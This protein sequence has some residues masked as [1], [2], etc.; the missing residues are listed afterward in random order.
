LIDGIAYLMAPGP[1]RF[2]QELAGELYRQI[3]NALLGKRYRPFIAPFDVRSQ[4]ADELVDTV[5]QPD[6]FVVCD[7][8][9]IDDRGVRARPTG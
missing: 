1:G 4:Q 6:V 2:H 5:V 9:K 7:P 3:A 8:R